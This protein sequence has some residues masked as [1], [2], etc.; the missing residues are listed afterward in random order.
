M[1]PGAKGVVVMRDVTASTHPFGE[2]GRVD[3][4]SDPVPS[5]LRTPVVLYHVGAQTA[6][7][8]RFPGAI[9]ERPEAA[10]DLAPVDLVQSLG[11]RSERTGGSTR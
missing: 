7:K 1:L 2:D 10:R 3:Q 5:T 4:E 6:D 8:P 11:V 9:P